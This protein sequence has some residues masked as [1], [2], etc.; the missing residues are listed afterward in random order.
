[1]KNRGIDMSTLPDEEY[2]SIMY[3][4]DAYNE[5]GNQILNQAA[6]KYRRE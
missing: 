3:D 1:M 2:N 4:T 6:G 5:F